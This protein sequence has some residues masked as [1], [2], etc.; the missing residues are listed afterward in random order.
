M[1]AAL[2]AIDGAMQSIKTEYAETGQTV[3][4]WEKIVNALEPHR[5]LL[6]KQTCSPDRVGVLPQNRP[7]LRLSVSKTYLN[8]ARHCMAGWSYK[9]ASADAWASTPPSEKY[10]VSK[11]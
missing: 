7:G 10:G 8:A 1:E 3:G 5:S 9:K 2:G 4:A 11:V 6:F